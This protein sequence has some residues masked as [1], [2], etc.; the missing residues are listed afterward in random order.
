MSWKPQEKVQI[1]GVIGSPVASRKDL[2]FEDDVFFY[3]VSLD[4]R[5]FDAN[6]DTSWFFIGQRSE[7][8]VDRQAVGAEFRFFDEIRSAFATVDY[9]LHFGELN[10]AI[11]SGSWTFTDKSTLS[12]GA[13][14]RKSPALF[15][16]NAL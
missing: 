5:P 12:L 14:Y 7:D 6:F 10:T 9:D 11:F 15:T 2:P 8:F 4:Y 13:D 1:N 3:G 16:T